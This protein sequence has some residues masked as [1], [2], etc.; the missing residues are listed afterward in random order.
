MN[1]IPH[2]HRHAP[3]LALVSLGLTAN[4]LGCSGGDKGKI[5]VYHY[6]DFYTPDLKHVA[7]LPFANRSPDFAAGD[8][9][10]GRIS[11]IL[12]NNGTYEVYTRQNLTDILAEKDMADAGIIEGEQA[13]EIGR[14]KSVQAL[15]C[16]VCDRFEAVSQQEVRYQQQP[17]FGYDAYGNVIITGF[18]NVPYQWTR[19]DAFVECRVVIIDTHTGR[20][21]GAVTDPSAIYSE[22][23]PPK[24][25]ATDVLRMAEEDQIAKIVRGIAVTR[26]QIKLKGKVLRTASGLY[27]NQWDWQ[28]T[29]AAD[30]NAMTVVVSL[31]PEADR[32]SFTIRIVKK[33]AREVLAEHSF[34]WNKQNAGQGFPFD[35][36]PLL[37][38]AGPGQFEAKLYSG[39]EPIAWYTFNLTERRAR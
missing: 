17:Q 18:V 9:I 29:F 4:L 34:E 28:D 20:Q 23:S 39:P 37:A 22:G 2:T 5:W 38:K 21:I 10:S 24:Y 35:I 25:Q 31:P 6:P 32:N 8:R 36:A 13:M 27:D 7:V 14:L 33:D 12:T 30:A 19:H 1:R 26:T 16:G 3:F 11:A 15:I